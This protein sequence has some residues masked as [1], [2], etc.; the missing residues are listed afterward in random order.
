MAKALQDDPILIRRAWELLNEVT[1]E[2]LLG[3]GRVDGGGLHIL[4]PKELAN[5][6]VPA[7]AAQITT[8]HRPPS[9]VE[10]FGNMTPEYV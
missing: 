6:P 8:A 7:L 1:P 9:Q 10:M 2:Q 4:E 5:V 3:E